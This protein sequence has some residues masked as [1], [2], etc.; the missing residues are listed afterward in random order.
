MRSLDLFIDFSESQSEY[1][2][3]LVEFGGRPTLFNSVKLSRGSIYFFFLYNIVL[4]LLL[5]MIG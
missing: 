4:I 1:S 2:I 3:F 5:V